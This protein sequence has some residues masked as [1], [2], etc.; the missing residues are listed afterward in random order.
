MK[1]PR[2]PKDKTAASLHRK[3]R[4]I[5]KYRNS[6]SLHRKYRIEISMSECWPE[7]AKGPKV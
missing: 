3:Y 5:A 2:A 1:V 6:G 4:K 7:G